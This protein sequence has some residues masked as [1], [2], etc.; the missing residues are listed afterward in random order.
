MRSTWIPLL[1][2]QVRLRRPR[3]GKGAAGAAV[4]AGRSR[5]S[6]P[7]SRPSTASLPEAP[8]KSIAWTSESLFR[9]RPS[10][11]REDSSDAPFPRATVRSRSRASLEREE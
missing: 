2:T 9:S 10:I 5:A 8:K 3:A 7:A 6:T 11:P 1:V 4:R